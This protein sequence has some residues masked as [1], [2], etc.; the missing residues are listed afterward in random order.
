MISDPKTS[1][2]HPVARIIW[3]MMI[4]FVAFYLSAFKFINNAAIWVLVP[5]GM[6]VPLLNVLLKAKKFSWREDANKRKSSFQP[7][8]LKFL[9]TK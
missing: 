4:A 1:P 5:A 7:L 2:Q 8:A 9:E 3:A 6:I